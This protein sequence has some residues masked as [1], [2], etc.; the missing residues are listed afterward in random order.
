M[1]FTE[2]FNVVL[3]NQN[4]TFVR[5]EELNQMTTYGAIKIDREKLKEYKRDTTIIYDEKEYS[6]EEIKKYWG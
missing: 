6:K 4:G 1:L 5:I 3:S 2:D